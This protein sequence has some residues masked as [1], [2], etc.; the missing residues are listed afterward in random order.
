MSVQLL[1][2]QCWHGLT[3]EQLSTQA[4]A[5][6]IKDTE[7]IRH[8]RLRK[9][10]VTGPSSGCYGMPWLECWHAVLLHRRV[11]CDSSSGFLSNLIAPLRRW[12][13][14]KNKKP[15]DKHNTSIELPLTSPLLEMV[16]TASGQRVI[17][18]HRFR[19]AIENI[20]KPLETLLVMRCRETMD[21]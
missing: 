12:R 19:V 18:C 17:C 11:Q 21:S 8:D 9:P 16:W 13:V 7:D 10:L 1:D 2:L 5:A 3:G 14:L 20:R 4:T 15:S 6:C